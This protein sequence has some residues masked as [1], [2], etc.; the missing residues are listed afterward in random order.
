M[1]Y[2]AKDKYY[3]MK[4]SYERLRQVSTDTGST[5]TNTDPR[6]ATGDFF[7]QCYHF[8]DW[9][10]KDAALSRSDVEDFITASRALSFA[11]D[12]CNASKHGGLDKPPRSGTPID[13]ANTRITIDL[14]GRSAARGIASGRILLTIGGKQ[15]DAFELATD[16]MGDW[17]NYLALKGVTFPPP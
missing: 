2:P 11:A 12:Y 16:C 13:K 15:I 1:E 17:D 4:R 14:S 6:D 3:S 9:L 10:K 8:K 5:I 7:S